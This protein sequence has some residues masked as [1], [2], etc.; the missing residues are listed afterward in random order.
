[1]KKNILFL[2]VIWILGCGAGQIFSR[3]QTPLAELY[4]TGKINLKL[5]LRITDENLPDG[6]FFENPMEMT[7]DEAGNIYVVDYRAHH[8]KKFDSSG[9]FLKVLGGEG[10]GPGEFNGPYRITFAKDKLAV[11]ELRGRRVTTLDRSFIFFD[12]SI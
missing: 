11:Y 12:C 2:G 3:A 6:M 4:K 9:K 10:E 5:D 8:I 7:C 1:M